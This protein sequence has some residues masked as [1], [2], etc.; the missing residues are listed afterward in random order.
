MMR[1]SSSFVRL[2]LFTFFPRKE[3]VELETD[4]IYLLIRPLARPVVVPIVRTKLHMLANGKKAPRV[5]RCRA[6]L[7]RVAKDLYW[8]LAVAKLTV[9]RFK[10]LIEDSPEISGPPSTRPR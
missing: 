9:V 4:R 2:P 8:R 3:K 1:P 7:Q 6:P 5:P 10:A